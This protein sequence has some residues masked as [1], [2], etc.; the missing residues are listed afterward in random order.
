MRNLLLN[1]RMQRMAPFLSPGI[2]KLGNDPIDED[3]FTSGRPVYG[4]LDLSVRTDLSA[5]VLA[6][7]DDDG[8]VHL[9]P[10]IWTPADTMLDRGLRDRAPYQVWAEQ[11]LMIAV[12]GK[13]LDYDFLAADIGEL[14]RPDG[15]SPRLL[16]T[17][18][19]S[20]SCG[21]RWRGWAS[22]SN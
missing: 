4:G 15:D 13:V 2:W 17:D 10:R 19:A 11:G 22:L 3:L 8:V 21:S 9:M 14:S 20:T 18:G 5:L 1:Q 6:V 12:P 7:E 16:M